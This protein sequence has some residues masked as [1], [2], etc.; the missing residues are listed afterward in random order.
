MSPPEKK[1]LEVVDRVE[2]KGKRERKVAILLPANL[3][4]QL[5]TLVNTRALGV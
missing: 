5:D 3:R 2:L 1:L 4:Q